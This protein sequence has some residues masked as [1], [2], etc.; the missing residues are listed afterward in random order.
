MED[1]RDSTQDTRKETC[2]RG[3]VEGS[4]L[5]K[6]GG[7]NEDG[8]ATADCLIYDIW[9]KHWSVTPS[10]IDMLTPRELFTAAVLDG[11]IVVAGGLGVELDS[12]CIAI[13]DLLEYAPLHFPLPSLVFNRIL[14]IG[15]AGDDRGGE[16]DA[17]RKKA[18]IV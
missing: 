3:F 6:I 12:E 10:S 16:D 11:K 4:I 17:P 5:V 18:K 14:E 2:S 9:S 15:K 7:L 1:L 13:D 8:Y